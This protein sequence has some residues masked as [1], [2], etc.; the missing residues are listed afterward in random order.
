[1]APVFLGTASGTFSFNG[2]SGAADHPGA[3]AAGDF[4]GDGKSDLVIVNSSRYSSG[5]SS[6]DAYFLKG[7]GDGSFKAGLAFKTDHADDI[8]V[9][10]FNGDK[11]LD[12]AIASPSFTSIYL[13]GGD[14]SFAK[15]GAGIAGSAQRLAV[16]DINGDGFADIAALGSNRNSA[17]DDLVRVAFG[18]GKGNFAAGLVLSVGDH[19]VGVAL[20]DLNKDGYADVIVVNNLSNDVSIYVSDSLGDFLPEQRVDAGNGPMALAVADFTEDGF[21]DIAV[22]DSN[23]LSDGTLGDGSV[24]LLVTTAVPEPAT[25]L[26]MLAGLGLLGGVARW[27]RRN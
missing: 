17:A 27:Q 10:D 24:T 21:L 16:G 6:L 15:L 5:A 25:Y 22:T 20:A 13:G 4:D 14:G 12:F 26:M 3:V 18:D 11:K 23:P 7:V 8:V 2:C 1:M 19:P 9:A